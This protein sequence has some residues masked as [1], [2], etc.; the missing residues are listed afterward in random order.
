MTRVPST[1]VTSSEIEA[2]VQEQGIAGLHVPR[3]RFVGDAHDAVRAVRRIEGRVE[4]E[5][6]AFD[7]RRAARGKAFDA[8]LGPAQVAQ[9]ADDTAGPRR[10]RPCAL[11]APRVLVEAAVRKID[12]DQVRAGFDQVLERR[13]GIGRRS[14]RRHDLGASSHVSSR[15]CGGKSAARRSSAAT[16]G[17]VLPSTNSRKAPPPVEI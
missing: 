8:H 16:A 7:Q 14:E 1:P 2:V 17:R 15:Q 6:L 11:D 12:A 13:L 5:C 3:Q 4:R 9:D 10:G